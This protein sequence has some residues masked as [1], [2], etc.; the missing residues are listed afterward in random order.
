MKNLLK[1]FSNDI[2]RKKYADGGSPIFTEIVQQ[3]APCLKILEFNVTKTSGNT[4]KMKSAS[5][6][7][8]FQLRCALP[9]TF[10]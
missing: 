3:T 9:V 2:I 8:T 4:K 1:T 6:R 10:D 5:S 7:K